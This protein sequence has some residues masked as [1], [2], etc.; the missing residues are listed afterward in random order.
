MRRNFRS[1]QE[2]SI[3]RAISTILN[4]F[5][6]EKLPP[7][8]ID[9]MI[10]LVTDDLSFNLVEVERQSWKAIISDN[11]S[12][13]LNTEAEA[14]IHWWRQKK[15]SPIYATSLKRKK[16]GKTGPVVTMRL[17]D[18]DFWIFNQIQFGS[19]MF[20]KDLSDLGRQRISDWREDMY[21]SYPLSFIVLSVYDGYGGTAIAGPPELVDRVLE[22][23]RD[24][25]EK[26]PIHWREM[27]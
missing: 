26:G 11:N 12:G 15:I 1:K 19:W 17:S 8:L 7:D 23:S 9:Q 24:S 27:L 4:S 16:M 25:S 2:A 20:D 22:A 18:P 5:F 6:L 21:F 14:L 3:E 13:E 10:N